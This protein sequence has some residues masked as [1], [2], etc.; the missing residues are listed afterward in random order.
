MAHQYRYL[1]AIEKAFDQ[2][3]TATHQLIN[4]YSNDQTHAWALHSPRPDAAWLETALLDYWYEEGQDGRSTRP[5]IGMIAAG[6][7]LLEAVAAV[8]AAK[9]VFSQVLAEIKREEKALIPELKGSLPARHPALASNLSGAG[10]ARLNLKQCWR[11]IP[12]ADA[13]VERV[14]LSWYTSGRSIKRLTVA[15]VEQKLMS[16]NT[17]SQHVE[18]LMKTL[19]SVPSREPLAQVQTLA[20]TMR[21]NLF[22][23]DP[24]RDGRDRRAMNVPLPLFIPSIDGRLPLHNQP[25]PFPPES[26]TRKVRSDEKLEE[27][28]FLPSLRIYRYR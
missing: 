9:S 13:P 8:N 14:H 4:Q 27:E 23:I 3:V 1:S 28:P 18:I 26:R 2:I 6:P 11:H 25:T 20:P 15:A 21:A 17:D 22:F 24:L 5:Y 19:A 7:D 10:L 16:M 12:V